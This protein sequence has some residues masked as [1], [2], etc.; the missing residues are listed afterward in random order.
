MSKY[1]FFFFFLLLFVGCSGAQKSTEKIQVDLNNTASS[2]VAINDDN[3]SKDTTFLREEERSLDKKLSFLTSDRSL[4]I[5]RPVNRSVYQ[6]QFGTLSVEIKDNSLDMLKVY[7]DNFLTKTIELKRDET[8]FCESV[9]F[10]N[11]LNTI[12]IEAYKNDKIVAEVGVSLFV[13]S[14]LFK[15]YKYPPKGYKKNY[16]HNSKNESKCSS[17]HKMYP[18][19]TLDVPFS[20][21]Q[22]SNCYLCHKDLV[23]RK[24]VHNKK[25]PWACSSCHG[26]QTG[27][28][29]STERGK[30][31][32][33]F[34]DPI[35]KKCFSCHKKEEKVWKSKKVQHEPFLLGKCN[36]CHNPHSS[37]TMGIVRESINELC[38]S[39]HAKKAKDGH[40]VNA[41]SRKRHPVSGFKDPTD[42]KREL[43]CTSCH[44]PHAS[45]S[46]FLTQNDYKGYKSLCI[47]C[48]KK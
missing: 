16:F 39:C 34:P 3:I 40:I 7:V 41:F 45:N 35:A 5:I 25:N 1:S 30:S 19:D 43:R 21:P 44:N 38:L 28:L 14:K 11:G 26:Y 15:K 4:R 37:D 36:K 24:F 47:M 20:K 8:I 46:S 31:K 32:F 18:N 2:K 33:L 17:C 22:M 27:K 6:E 10:N 29:N 42:P 9:F 13:V 48:H 12:K 23:S